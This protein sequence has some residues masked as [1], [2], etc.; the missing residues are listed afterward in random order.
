MLFYMVNMVC[1]LGV[2]F[3]IGMMFIWIH[4]YV[5]C[6]KIEFCYFKVY[7]MGGNFYNVWIVVI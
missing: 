2:F 1:V 3:K 4:L 7:K 6:F 5:E